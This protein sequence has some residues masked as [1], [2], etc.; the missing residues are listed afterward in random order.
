MGMALIKACDAVFKDKEGGSYYYKD[1]HY[2]V[3]LGIF[4]TRSEGAP[5]YQIWLYLAKDGKVVLHNPTHN[6]DK[7]VFELQRNGVPIAE[8]LEKAY[9][10]FLNE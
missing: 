1:E 9:L 6:G 4:N 10:S 8:E 5:R 3:D 2:Y 7:V